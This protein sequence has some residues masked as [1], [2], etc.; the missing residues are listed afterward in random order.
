MFGYENESDVIGRRLDE[1]LHPDYKKPALDIFL[2]SLTSGETRL[3]GFEGI[4]I[5]A[6]GSEIYIHI[7][8]SVIKVDDKVKG[9]QSHLRDLSDWKETQ[10]QL[11]QQREELSK[12]AHSM[13]HDLRSSIHVI[14][15]LADL[16]QED[17]KEKHLTDIV[18]IAEKMD[19]IL[20]KS[21]ALAEAGIII[22]TKTFVNLEELIREVALTS[23]PDEIQLK[24]GGLPSLNCD[25]SK[26]V[27]VM[28]NLMQNAHEHGK[29]TTI[30]IASK[31][32]EGD[33]S[34]SIE[35]D[36]L[37]IP[38]EFRNRFFEQGFSTKEKGGLGLEII[39]SIVEAHGWKIT[40]E[41]TAPATIQIQI[42][43]KDIRYDP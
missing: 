15:G 16:Y 20:T 43:A 19:A 22:G 41:N 35:N 21:V 38:E 42:P 10:E 7:S 2:S 8:S 26:M 34:I 31:I 5:R 37:P 33:F 28:Q 18:G 30:S 13:A 12:F 3:D 40:L 1:F 36:G 27:Q 11:K 6:D 4:G 23:I 17:R 25:R 32:K 14:V 39:K 29:A 24:L 9:F